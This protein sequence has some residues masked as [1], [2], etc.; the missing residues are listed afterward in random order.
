MRMFWPEC[1]VG[2]TT[3]EL[4]DRQTSCVLEWPYERTR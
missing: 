3:A 4:L 2:S 1:K